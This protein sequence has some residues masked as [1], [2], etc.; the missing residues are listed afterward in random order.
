[1]HMVSNG[2]GEIKEKERK[3]K[4]QEKEKRKN[5][6]ISSEWRKKQH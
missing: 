5:N 3:K 4:E 2:L 6:P 1:M